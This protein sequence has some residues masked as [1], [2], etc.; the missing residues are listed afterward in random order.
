MLIRRLL[1]KDANLF[2][3]IVYVGY[4]FATDNEAYISVLILRSEPLLVHGL[5]ELLAP[6]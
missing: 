3:L 6:S 4:S 5:R 1:H 2:P